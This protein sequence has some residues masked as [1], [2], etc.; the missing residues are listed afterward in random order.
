MSFEKPDIIILS[1]DNIYLDQIPYQYGCAKCL[2]NQVV[3]NEN[4]CF[5]NCFNWFFQVLDLNASQ[6]YKRLLRHPDFPRSTQDWNP[7]WL[8]TWGAHDSSIQNKLI[9]KREFI[10]FYSKLNAKQNWI[11]S[12]PEFYAMIQ[13]N[14]RGI[15][16]HY[17]HKQRIVD[18]VID[19]D[20]IMLDVRYH[21]SNNDMLGEAQWQWL[22]ELLGQIKQEKPNWIVFVLGTTFL[23]QHPDNDKSW[24]TISRLRLERFMK[25]SGLSRERILILSGDVSYSVIHDANGL[26]EL[27]VSSFT[28]S[29]GPIQKCCTSLN[30]YAISDAICVNGYGLLQFT[31]NTW[32]FELRNAEQTPYIP[33]QVNAQQMM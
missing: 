1:G 31:R 17:H 24:D 2:N 5:S 20:F 12:H 15:Y 18:G 13:S 3:D 11:R 30:E 19:V 10:Q 33:L 7:I 6:E 8:A 4:E 23:L 9:N 21:R 28:H 16:H 27:T 22:Q 29:L 14:D 25:E 32:K 26:K